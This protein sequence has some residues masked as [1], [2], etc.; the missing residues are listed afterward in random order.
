MNNYLCPT[1]KVFTCAVNGRTFDIHGVYFRQQ[2]ER[3]HVCAHACL[4]MSLNERRQEW[5]GSAMIKSNAV[6][7]RQNISEGLTLDEM[8]AVV[9]QLGGR[10][11]EVIDCSGME[12]AQYLAIIASIVESGDRALLVFPTHKAG[13]EHV[14]TVFGHTR[15][16][17][18]WHPQAIPAYAGPSAQFYTSSMWIDHFDP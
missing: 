2:N 1:G 4:R 15:N 3:T 17:D 8:V 6:V 5:D 11:A 10:E 14:V 9:E 7:A 18:E 12:P 13:E 16:S